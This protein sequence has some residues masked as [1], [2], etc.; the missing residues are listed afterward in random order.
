MTNILI[1]NPIKIFVFNLKQSENI[2]KS[3]KLILPTDV[4][5]LSGSKFINKKVNE[6][7]KNE[8]IIDIKYKKLGG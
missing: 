3:K 8:T 5:V 7:Q 4:I 2:L 6:V 1:P